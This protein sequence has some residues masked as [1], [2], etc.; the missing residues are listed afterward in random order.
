M[1]REQIYLTNWKKNSSIDEDLIF[2][3][4]RIFIN[5]HLLHCD[6][7]YNKYFFEAFK[8]DEGSAT[9]LEVQMDVD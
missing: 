5:L 7:Y 3:L 4:K 1:F 9:S 8:N 6:S 2:Q